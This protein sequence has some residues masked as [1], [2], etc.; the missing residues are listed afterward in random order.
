MDASRFTNLIAEILALRT[1]A[2]VGA[3]RNPQKFGHKVYKTLKRHGYS[4]YA[5]NPN[6]DE[7][8][9]DPA[10]P[11]LDNVPEPIECVVTVVPPEVT[12]RVLREAWH[13]KIPYC[14]M[15]PGSESEAAV[16]EALS[17]GMQVVYG[18]AC[19]MVESNARAEQA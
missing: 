1:F 3:S 16:N 13:L 19:I 4:V 9:G 7:I 2:V 18:G 5:V 10:Y 17:Y 6:A 15:Q 11:H 8:D 14:W 12:E